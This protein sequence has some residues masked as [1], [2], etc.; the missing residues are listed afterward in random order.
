MGAAWDTDIGSVNPVA[1]WIV[2][3]LFSDEGSVLGHNVEFLESN[4]YRGKS[5][6]C[7]YLVQRSS[8]SRL[9]LRHNVMVRIHNLNRVLEHAI[10][11]EW[12][13]C[14]VVL[15]PRLFS[16]SIW[17]LWY[18]EFMPTHVVFSLCILIL[19]TYTC[20]A[21]YEVQ[22]LNPQPYRKACR[23]RQSGGGSWPS[24]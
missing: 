12:R 18:V 22:T 15:K 5:F 4:I 7:Y 3:E 23:V 10:L 1:Q 21:Y 17:L 19:H 13:Q 24:D 8:S 2:E 16:S 9:L 14:L 11:V 6:C 20:P